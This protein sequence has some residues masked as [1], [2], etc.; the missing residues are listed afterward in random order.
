M[1][2]NNID[3]VYIKWYRNNVLNVLCQE[4]KNHR[5]DPS[6]SKVNRFIF[7]FIKSTQKFNESAVF[8]IDDW[9]TFLNLMKSCMIDN[10]IGD[11]DDSDSDHDEK[12][13]FKHPVTKESIDITEVHSILTH[14]IKE[15]AQNEYNSNIL[16]TQLKE[17]I[18]LLLRKAAPKVHK[19]RFFDMFVRIAISYYLEGGKGAF[20]AAL[21]KGEEEEDENE[22]TFIER[23][24]DL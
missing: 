24:D 19:H 11:D 4:A 20:K 10:H 9:N 15:F 2:N 17:S 21:F 6:K 14:F 5:D 22:K 12:L 13:N 16:T 3:H 8:S 18:L 7:S 1:K 23:E